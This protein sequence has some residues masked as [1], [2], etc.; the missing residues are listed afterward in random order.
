MLNLIVGRI[1]MVFGLMI[2]AVLFTYQAFAADIVVFDVHRNIP[3]SD[4]DPVF[5]DYYINGGDESGLKKDLVVKAVRKV[6]MKDAA[7]VQSLG[8]MFVPVGQL[9]ILQVQG[10]L[11][12]ARLY[13]DLS[14]DEYAVTEQV[15]VMTGDHI[16]LKDSFIDK[17]KIKPVVKKVAVQAPAP[18]PIAAPAP[19]LAPAPAPVA[20]TKAAPAAP[21]VKPPAAPPA[22]VAAVPPAVAPAPTAA[23]EPEP[24]APAV[25]E[26]AQT[27][28][29]AKAPVKAGPEESSVQ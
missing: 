3:L 5:Q 2:F 12:V 11:S 28:T 19:A 25:R 8:E 22:P 27:T 4:D 15:G 14:R 18:A 9:R 1:M 6:T 26:P 13:K 20:E 16:D 10:R 17:K 29:E 21:E 7:G 23:K 24:E